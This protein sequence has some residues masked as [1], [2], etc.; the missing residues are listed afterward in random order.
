MATAPTAL[1]GRHFLKEL[2]FTAQE[3]RG[4]IELAAELKAAKKAGA[5]SQYLRGKNIALIFEKTSTRTRCAFEVAAADQGASTTYLDPSGSQ[6]GHKESVKDT[7][8]VLGRMYDGIQYRGDSQANVEELAA[9]AG[10][11]VYNGLTDAWHPTQ[12]LADV[13]T[14][15]EHTDKPLSE[16][17]FAYL[18]DARFNMGNSYLITGAILGMD[19]RIVAPQAYWPAKDVIAEA[20]RI[21]ETSGARITFTETVAEGVAGVDFVATD[22]WVSMGE[23]KEVWDERIAAL[24]PYAVTMDVLRATGNADVKFLHCLPAFHDLGTKVGREIHE[25]HGLDSLEVTDEVFESAHSVVFD[26]AENRLHTIKAVL[27]ATLA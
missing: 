13:L 2:D 5:E 11:P 14:M 10:V 22:V 25:R 17:A 1:A 26:E 27:V 21:G 8:R 16:I 20:H 7:A 19:V 12:M 9:Y 6:I 15:T 23:P 24:G 3:F 18:G 4:L